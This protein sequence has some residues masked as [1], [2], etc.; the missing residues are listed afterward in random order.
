[1]REFFATED[2]KRL[3]L[4]CWNANK[5]REG[6]HDI[7]LARRVRELEQELAAMRSGGI[8]D[9]EFIRLLLQLTHPDRHGGSRAATE[10]TRRLL[11]MKSRIN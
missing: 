10:A 3:C 5:R 1:M 11:E 2:W 4:N 7:D 9:I 8:F 6:R